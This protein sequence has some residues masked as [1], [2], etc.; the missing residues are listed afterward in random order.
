MTSQP[1]APVPPPAPPEELQDVLTHVEGQVTSLELVE[2]LRRKGI[3]RLE[4][5]RAMPPP[6][7]QE[8]PPRAHTFFRLASVMDYLLRHSDPTRVTLWLDRAKRQMSIVLDEDAKAGREVLQYTPQFTTQFGAWQGRLG[9]PI[10][11]LALAD[12]L[13]EQRAAI[14]NGAE[15][16]LACKQLRI[17]KSIEIYTGTG[18]GAMNGVLCRTTVRSGQEQAQPVQFPDSLVVHL[19]VFEELADPVALDCDLLIS[20]SEGGGVVASLRAAGLNTIIEEA[21][22]TLLSPLAKTHYL[23]LAGEH[24][25]GCWS[26]LPRL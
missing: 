10:P 9:K 19:T 16:A 23:V 26:Y 13:N 2:D 21:F 4:V 15:L 17:S 18:Q 5:G 7:R 24:R 25:E 22:K 20:A 12:F 3:V 11:M 6:V 14:V 1:K 8:T